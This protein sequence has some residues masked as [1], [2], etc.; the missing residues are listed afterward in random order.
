[1]LAEVV[2]NTLNFEKNKSV[3]N[4][5]T[6]HYEMHSSLY[7]QR[8]IRFFDHIMRGADGNLEKL[9]FLGNVNGNRPKRQT[10]RT[11]V[12]QITERNQLPL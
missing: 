2:Q 8:I 4:D 9:I 6:G 10:S 12:D 5:S 3:N 11:W 1:M 7:H